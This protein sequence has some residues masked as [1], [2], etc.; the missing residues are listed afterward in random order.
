[1]CELK[2]RFSVKIIVISYNLAIIC[3]V[4]FKKVTTNKV[5]EISRLLLKLKYHLFR[6]Y[7]HR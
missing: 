4:L 1:M 2:K 7:L 6:I 5:L 3:N